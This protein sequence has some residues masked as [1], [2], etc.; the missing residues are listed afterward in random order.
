MIKKYVKNKK[1]ILE[2]A[3]VY[4]LVIYDDNEID[5]ILRKVIKDV[6]GADITAIAAG[7]IAREMASSV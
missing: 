2:A 3:G 7:V 5:E 6:A 4:S 1:V